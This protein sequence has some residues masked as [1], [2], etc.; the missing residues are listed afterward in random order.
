MRKIIYLTLLSLFSVIKA[1]S[2]EII[3]LEKGFNIGEK[4]EENGVFISSVKFGFDF[5]DSYLYLI[6]TKYGTILKVDIK[7]GKLIQTISSK[8]QGPG[9]LESPIQVIEKNNK[10][11]VLDRTWNGIKIFEKNGKFITS[12]HVLVE[13]F[14]ASFFI[15]ENFA[16]DEKGEVFISTPD[17]KEN[18]L[19]SVYDE[20]NGKRVRALIDKNLT[21]IKRREEFIEEC[22][23]GIR[24]D[25]EGSIYLLYPLKRILK[26]FTKDGKLLWERIVENDLIKE[27]EKKYGKEEQ[28]IEERAF[29]VRN[30][31]ISGF[32]VSEN[33]TIFVSHRGGGCI[34]DKN[35]DLVFLLKKLHPLIRIKGFKLVQSPYFF[36][37]LRIV[38]IPEKIKRIL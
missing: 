12:F 24:I 13:P 26:K 7:T 9:E 16:V 21:K 22:V 1:F 15:L 17:L 35:G 32:D 8:G 28:S 6:E 11:Y 2:V 25:K 36:D 34:F 27:E 3:T 20:R 18:K 38:R 10:L 23:Y 19:V 14:P 33:G 31:S 30:M 5:D 4:M 37:R 29:E